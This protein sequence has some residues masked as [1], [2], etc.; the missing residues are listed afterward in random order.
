VAIITISRGTKSGG[1]KLAQSLS[2]RLGYS[3]ISREIIL[4]GAKKY[5]ILEEELAGRLEESPNLWQKITRQHQRYLVFVQ[6]ALIDA[7]R[8]D[9]VIYHGYGGQLFLRG[10]THVLKVR[11]DAPLADRIDVVMKESEI[12]HE[13]A[14]DYIARI[15]EQRARWVKQTYGEDWR[16]P[17]LYDMSFCTGNMT[18]DSICEIIALAVDREEFKTTE[19]SVRALE[20]LSLE[21]EVLAA[22]AA[23]DKTWN[24]PVTVSASD[25][26]VTLRG[27]VKS[28]SLR[29]RIAEL[30][31][32][33]KGVKNCDVGIGLSTD[34]LSKGIYGHD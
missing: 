31:A 29:D 19:A 7:V 9:R 5:N 27:T 18:I 16:D 11:L 2:R 26:T 30:A 17:T 24:L 28:E 25:G 12:G 3:C 15:D 10:I 20:N 13:E 22:L 4:E 33:V 32:Q 23:D 34:P 21:C 6:C 14:E 8:K 1:L